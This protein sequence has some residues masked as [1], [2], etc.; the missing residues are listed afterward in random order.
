M[1]SYRNGL[2]IRYMTKI[3][4]LLPSYNVADYIDDCLRSVIEQSLKDIEI[5]C[6]DAGS[7]DGTLEI[8]K[9]Y[10]EKDDRIRVI[11][12]EQKSYGAQMNQGIQNARGKYIA[13]VE[14]DDYISPEMMERLYNVAEREKAD[15]AKGVYYRVFESRDGR[16]IE[17]EVHYIPARV[18]KGV[19]FSPYS[20]LSIHLWDSNIWNGIYRK[21]FLIENKI[22]FNETPGAAFQDIGFKHRVLFNAKRLV[23]I[24]EPFYHY[25][26]IRKGS[27]T[28]SNKC[29]EFAFHEYSNLLNEG[30]IGREHF[31]Y[32]Y[33]RLIPT[34][35]TEY[36][37][38]LQFEGFDYFK[39]NSKDHIR[40]FIDTIKREYEDNRGSALWIAD[41]YEDDIRECIYSPESYIK[42]QKE[43]FELISSFQKELLSLCEGS[44]MVLF[45]CGP[46]GEALLEFEK[47]NG[48]IPVAVTDN[49]LDL[50]GT[51]F[52][53]QMV[54]SPNDTIEKY[55]NGLYI[56][57][58]RKN[59]NII[60]DQLISK[61]ISE[62]RIYLINTTDERILK[63]L[64]RKTVLI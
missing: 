61:G 28:W 24:D 63:A 13:I 43:E 35:L 16:R 21:E 53:D 57:S 23:F 62:N 26:F 64:Q 4:V 41:I 5:I 25:R 48:V 42:K 33:A 39:L 52:H 51:L 45:G 19:V 10:A 30:G 2:G 11:N 15:V 32:I 49:N 58:C 17:N 38:S 34:F 55:P 40:W 7:S 60:K 29:L 20:D 44:E 27:S 14:T 3:S 12:C 56:V 8:I 1:V 50:W 31:S 37:K 18:R 54:L 36:Q 47:Y 59:K 22:R 46:Y 9:S 6:L